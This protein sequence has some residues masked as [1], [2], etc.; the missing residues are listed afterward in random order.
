[1]ERFSRQPMRFVFVFAERNVSLNRSFQF[2]CSDLSKGS[3]PR[4]GDLET[5]SAECSN[6]RTPTELYRSPKTVTYITHAGTKG[7]KIVISDILTVLSGMEK[8]DKSGFLFACITKCKC[9]K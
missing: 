6:C 8:L 7:N 1:V 3:I 4:I 5:T 9:L 2:L